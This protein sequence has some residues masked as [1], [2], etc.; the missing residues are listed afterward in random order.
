M[1]ADFMLYILV[2]LEY[3]YCINYP[4]T[5]LFYIYLKPYATLLCFSPSNYRVFYYHI[6]KWY[7]TGQN[8]IGFSLCVSLNYIMTHATFWLSH[9][10]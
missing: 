4:G 7:P 5:I 8:K 2:H 10:V 1:L 6:Y 3:Y 9:C